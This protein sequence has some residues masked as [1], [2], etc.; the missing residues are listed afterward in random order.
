MIT[1]CK[2]QTDCEIFL[3]FQEICELQSE[4]G[5]KEVQTKNRVTPNI[6]KFN[7]HFP[8]ELAA[9]F[10]P[11]LTAAICS[12]GWS[13]YHQGLRGAVFIAHFFPIVFCGSAAR[14]PGRPGC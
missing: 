2:I 8:V 13:L 4:R 14:L 10:Q 12:K 7:D 5:F 3:T 9:M 6:P 11:Q 1:V